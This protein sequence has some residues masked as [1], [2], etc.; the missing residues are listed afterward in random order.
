M[1]QV[2]LEINGVAGTKEQAKATSLFLGGTGEVEEVDP[3]CPEIFLIN[4]PENL[5]KI[6]QNSGFLEM[7]FNIEPGVTVELG[8]E[9]Y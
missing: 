4:L 9:A 8:I 2:E 1:W 6:V 7:K 3:D 5:D